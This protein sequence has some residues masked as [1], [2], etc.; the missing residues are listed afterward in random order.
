VLAYE[1]L[2]GALPWAG[3]RKAR[4]AAIAVVTETQPTLQTAALGLPAHVGAV[5]DQ[6][7]EKSPARRF[8]SMDA[9]VRAL[10]GPS[11]GR[12]GMTVEPSELQEAE[13]I[14]SD[15]DPNWRTVVDVPEGHDT[16]LATRKTRVN[17]RS[18]ALSGAR[19]AAPAR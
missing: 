17:N 6:A 7:L 3:G 4:A 2:S 5:I 9:L 16:E 15:A 18:T 14:S 19:R 13:T 11:E 12:T 8:V 1:L 10:D